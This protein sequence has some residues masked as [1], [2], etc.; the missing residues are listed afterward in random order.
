TK[1]VRDLVHYPLATV[2]PNENLESVMEKFN[3]TKYW[4]L[5]V[6]DGEKYVGFVSK[7]KLFNAYREKLLYFSE[8]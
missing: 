2:A 1:M 5:P 7:S 6:L 4:N 3:Q 8:E